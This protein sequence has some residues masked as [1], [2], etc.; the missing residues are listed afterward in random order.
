[1]S[2]VRLYKVNQSIGK[3][4]R[5][6]VVAAHSAS[7]AADYYGKTLVDVEH[8]GFN[9]VHPAYNGTE[10]YFESGSHTFYSDS[11]CYPFLYS[12]CQSDIDKFIENLS[13]KGRYP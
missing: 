6:D 3:D 11:V 9:E 12:Y 5:H 1:M 10:I 13:K 7:H 4:N 8:L 2:K